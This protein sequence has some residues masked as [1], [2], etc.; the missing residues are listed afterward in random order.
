MAGTW[1]DINASQTLGAGQA[2]RRNAGD[3][4]WEAFTPGGGGGTFSGG[5][6]DI[7]NTLGT[8]GAVTNRLVLA[9]GDNVTLSQSVNGGSATVTISAA[10]GGGGG[11]SGSYYDNMIQQNSA[12][13]LTYTSVSTG[14]FGRVIVQP[15]SPA[16]ELFPFHI[17]ASTAMLGFSNSGSS[18]ISAAFSSSW[19]IGVYT[20]NNSTQLSLLNSV[21][22]S[23]ALDAATNNSASFHGARWLSFH[24]SQW[25]SSPT[26][27]QGSRYFFGFLARTSGASY[28][29]H[30]IAGMHL[31]A[32][33]QRSGY[34]AVAA[35]ANTSSNAWHPFMGVHSLT[36]HTALPSTIANSQINK[37]S[38]Y[39]NF[40]PQLVMNAGL[41]VIN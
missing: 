3:N 25:S 36:T 37:A 18:N 22:T 5:M 24:Q 33:I 11:F 4:G 39:A 29:S 35:A 12:M 15:L 40:I 6:S 26:F 1:G 14:M 7:G 9:G 23:Y 32:S 17:T 2:L 16:N 19:Y 28:A 8:S 10:G 27:A 30:S 20:R 13:A 21:S 41:G 31:G 38:A 34:M